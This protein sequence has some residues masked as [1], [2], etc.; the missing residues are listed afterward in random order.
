MSKQR[1]AKLFI[2]LSR[3]TLREDRSSL[4]TLCELKGYDFILV[5]KVKIIDVYI[6]HG[7]A[8]EGLARYAKAQQQKQNA[9]ISH[10]LWTRKR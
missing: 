8:V 5:P 1:K 6:V 10:Y 2:Q 9:H 3:T 4:D 7:N